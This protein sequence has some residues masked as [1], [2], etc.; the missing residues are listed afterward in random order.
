MISRTFDIGPASASIWTAVWEAFRNGTNDVCSSAQFESIHLN[1]EMKR[2]L[3]PL[4]ALRAFEAA[5]RHESLQRAA[6]ELCVT[7]S[8]ISH[9][10]QKLE[11]WLG[12]QLF[13]RL[14]RKVVLTSDGREYFFTLSKAFD[15]ISNVT[16]LINRRKVKGATREKLKV[17]ADAGFAGCW[18]GA[19]L[20]SFQSIAP[21][22]QLEI[23]YGRD[24]DDY[25]KGQ[26][27]VAIHFGRGEWPEYQSIHLITGIEFPVC[28]PKLLESGL[29]LST[30]ADLTAFTLLHEGNVA[31]W[32][33]WLAAAGVTHRNIMGGPIFHSTAA[34]FDR[35]LAGQGAGLGDDIVAADLL[36][37]GALI[38]PLSL[39]RESDHS[40]Y[41]LQFRTDQE[42]RVVRVFREW[43]LREVAAHKAATAPLR[44]SEPFVL[45]KGL[46]ASA[47][48]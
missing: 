3:P 6:D 17:F 4:A 11:D 18:L 41:F 25:L 36:Y 1:G 26:S 13:R 33:N 14:N 38:K 7:P 46:P 39:V 37:A 43:L 15:E 40:L 47:E 10:V 35:V 27:D 12:V 45:G 5:A 48:G 8:S 30:P 21:D 9:Q 16:T 2:D 31:S 19:R 22:V 24:I 23:G 42:K 28:S 34:V 32:S 44:R 20:S 29:A